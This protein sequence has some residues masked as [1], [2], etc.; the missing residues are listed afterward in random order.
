MSGFPILD[1]VIGMIFIFFLLSII[2][3]SAVELVFTIL[4]TRATLLEE[5]LKR[6]FDKQALDSQGEL[7]YQPIME[8]GKPKI[9]EVKDANGQPQKDATGNPV[10]KPAP[11]TNKPI[12]I[13]QAIMDHCTARALSDTGKSPSYINVENFVTALLDKIT[14]L[15]R[16]KIQGSANTDGTQ[17]PPSNLREYIERIKSSPV[18][19]GELKRTFLAL[20]HEA[21]KATGV[22]DK[23]KSEL[24]HFRERLELWYNK[25]AERLTGK[26]KSSRVVPLTFVF[27]LLV[28]VFVNADSVAISRYLYTNK[29][30]TKQLADMAVAHLKKSET[31]IEKAKEELNSA[32]AADTTSAM[33]Q[34]TTIKELD[35]AAN[36][37]KED[38]RFLQD[39]LPP[40]LPLGWEKDKVYKP[41]GKKEVEWL[42]T[43][44]NGAEKHWVGWLVSILAICLG[45]PFW[46]DI[47]N[48][49]ASLRSSGV[50]PPT[51]GA[52]KDKTS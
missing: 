25:N 4:K 39:S 19:S 36:Q 43:L 6:I 50:R 45:A 22:S 29:E 11:D 49:V 37:L 46:Y 23:L 52:T 9:E 34:A 2:C 38:V 3:S 51:D 42:K 14:L 1:L 48:K 31:R 21:D 8:N 30:T 12:S 41:N 40:G 33:R 17:N 5:W 13:G 27:A 28:T 44:G 7:A 32:K 26:Y 20:A 10:K 15:P 16:D 24:D 18:I 47:L 35:S